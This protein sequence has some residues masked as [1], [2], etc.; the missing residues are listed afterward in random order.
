VRDDDAARRDRLPRLRRRCRRAP[1]GGGAGALDFAPPLLVRRVRLV[2]PEARGVGH[3]RERR[4]R[5]PSAL[6]DRLFGID[7]RA[8]ATFR[9]CAGLLLLVDLLDRASSLEL[10]YAD[11]GVLPRTDL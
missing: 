9:I 6:L 10:H 3:V 1:L 5:A 8:L 2:G 7:L 11:A 4:A